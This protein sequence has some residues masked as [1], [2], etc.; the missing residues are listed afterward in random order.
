MSYLNFG[1][2]ALFAAGIFL[3]WLGSVNILWSRTQLRRQTEYTYLQL[4]FNEHMYRFLEGNKSQFLQKQ[5]HKWNTWSEIGKG[6]PISLFALAI[7]SLLTAICFGLGTWLLTSTVWMILLSVLT[8]C[9]FPFLMLKARYLRVTYQA[10]RFGLLPYIDVYKNAYVAANYNVI[11]AFHISE[12]DCPKEMRPVLEWMLRRLHDGSLQREAL[13]EFA[14][15]L[16]SEWA[17]VFVNYCISGLE[18]EAENIARS[19]TH[20]QIEMHGM[21][22]EEEEREVV[23]RSAFYANFAIIALTLVG[24]FFVSLLLPQIKR[25]FIQ[26]D[27]GRVLLSLAV[28]TWLVTI[29]YSY[30]RLKGGDN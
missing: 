26:Q 23:T 25:F 30:F 19:L 15:I 14:T 10:R 4:K 21:R 11:T 22:D 27:T 9:L 12:Q 29:T 7:R 8:G 18:G 5:F 3:I 6:E 24:I 28:W 1:L 13:R 20:L 17:Q 2:I 16:H